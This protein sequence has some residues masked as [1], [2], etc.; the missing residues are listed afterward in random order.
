[1]ILLNIFHSKKNSTQNNEYATLN[2]SR[3]L[4]WRLY[5]VHI[6]SG[7]YFWRLPSYLPFCNVYCCRSAPRALATC[8]STSTRK[9]RHAKVRPPFQKKVSHFCNK[10]QVSEPIAARTVLG[11]NRLSQT[12]LVCWCILIVLERIWALSR[13]AD[14]LKMH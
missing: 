3:F 11:G 10:P 2:T 5:W 13:L 4:V 8:S 14:E 6:S 7:Q 9:N 1:M 12:K